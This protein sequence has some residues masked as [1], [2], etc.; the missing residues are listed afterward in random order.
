MLLVERSKKQ[1][2]CNDERRRAVWHDKLNV[3]RSTV[4]TITHV[5]YSARIQTV[6]SDAILAT[7]LFQSLKKRLVVTRCEHFI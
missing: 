4:P 3:P 7:T 5:D 1:A 2:P 6:H